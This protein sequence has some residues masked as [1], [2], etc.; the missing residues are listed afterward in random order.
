MSLLL[1]AGRIVAAP[2][3]VFLIQNVGC[4]AQTQISSGLAGVPDLPRA[5]QKHLSRWLGFCTNA[6]LSPHARIMADVK[7]LNSVSRANDLSA[8]VQ[9]LTHMS[10]H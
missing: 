10:K 1:K 3:F 7:T 2:L 6:A 5:K 4:K 8:R 9:D